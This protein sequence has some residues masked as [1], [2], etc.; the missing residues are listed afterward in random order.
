MLKITGGYLA[1]RTISSLQGEDTRPPLT[2]V[3]EAVANILQAYTEEAGML[4]LFA[5]TGSYSFELLSRG[6]KAAVLIDKNPKAVQVLRKNAA[7]LGVENRVQIVR[8]DALQVIQRFKTAGENFDIIMVAPPYFT[9]LDQETMK[10]LS[11]ATLLSPGGIVVLQQARKEKFSEKYG[12]LTLRKTY[13]YGDTRIS[14]Y[15][16][17]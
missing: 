11:S 8:A 5:G 14:T 3:R 15:I 9:G 4:D 17:Y 16:R 6:A 13:R 12:L 10:K 2:R 7:K 1:G